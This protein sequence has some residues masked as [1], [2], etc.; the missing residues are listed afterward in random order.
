MSYLNDIKKEDEQTL[1]PL[2]GRDNKK[3]KYDYTSEGIWVSNC[4]NHRRTK[5]D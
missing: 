5:P 3:G 2:F 4:Q 1:E